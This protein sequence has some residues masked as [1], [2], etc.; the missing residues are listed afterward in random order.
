MSIATN[1]QIAQVTEFLAGDGVPASRLMNWSV[2]KGEDRLPFML[3]VSSDILNW[4]TNLYGST[5]AANYVSNYMYSL[6]GKYIQTA[7]Q[8]INNA[9]GA[10]VNPITG[11]GSSVSAFTLQFV[12]GDASSPM[13]A[14]QTSLTLNYANV[15]GS[16]VSAILDGIELP[17]NLSDRTSYTVAYTQNSITI[18]FNQAVATGQVYIIRGLQYVS[19]SGGTPTPVTNYYN[20]EYIATADGVTSFTIAALSGATVLWAAKDIMPLTIG[21]DYTVTGVGLVTLIGSSLANGETFRV[22]Y[23]K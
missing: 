6:C 10:I 14:G 11:T 21:V 1:I 19:T 3:Y 8:I 15:V 7:S 2:K 20:A 4:Y 12:I 17:Y 5:V 23:V 22:L 18:T 9:A 13:T 16:S